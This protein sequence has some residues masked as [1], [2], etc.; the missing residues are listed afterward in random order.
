VP[1][2]KQDWPHF[3]TIPFGASFIDDPPSLF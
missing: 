3:F 2:F 1:T